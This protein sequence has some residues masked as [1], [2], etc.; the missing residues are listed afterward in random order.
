MSASVSINVT[1][2][3]KPT[4]IHDLQSRGNQNKTKMT[5]IIHQFTTENM[6]RLK[7]TKTDKERDGE[8]KTERGEREWIRPVSNEV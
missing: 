1:A 2:I 8:G 4:G 6:Y 7:E 3:W 5:C